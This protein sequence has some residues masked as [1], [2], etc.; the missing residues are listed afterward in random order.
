MNSVTV[1]LSV[2][3]TALPSP[4]AGIVI[5]LVVPVPLAV[6]PAPTKLIVSAA[7][8]RDDPSS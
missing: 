8:E 3:K 4:A 2:L 6:T 5:V 7:V 1:T